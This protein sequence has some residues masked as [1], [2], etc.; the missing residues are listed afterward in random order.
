MLAEI[1]PFFD[2]SRHKLAVDGLDTALD[3]LEV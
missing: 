2:H 1:R 3:V